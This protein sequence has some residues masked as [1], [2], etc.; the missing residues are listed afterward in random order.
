MHARGHADL[1]KT[2]GLE[3]RHEGHTEQALT[4]GVIAQV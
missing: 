3:Q 4:L 2:A 1:G